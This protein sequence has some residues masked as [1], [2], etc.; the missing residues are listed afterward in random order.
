MVGEGPKRS[1]SHVIYG[2]Y[3][4]VARSLDISESFLY[5]IK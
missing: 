3:G 4:V 2:D 5:K 1:C